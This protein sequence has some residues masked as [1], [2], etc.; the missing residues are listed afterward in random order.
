MLSLSMH[1]HQ[2]NRASLHLSASSVSV[3]FFFHSNLF[4]DPIIQIYSQIS[5]S[6]G[7]VSQ[8]RRGEDQS[9]EKEE[10]R[11]M[12]GVGENIMVSALTGVMSPVLGKLTKLIEKK[13][14]ELK[15]L[16]KK[17][18]QLREEL[19][20]INL[21][22]EKYAAV[23]SPGVQAKAWMAEMREL[24]YDMEDSI[25]LFS[26]HVGYEPADTTRVKSFF[27]KKIRKLKKLHYRY[28]FAE[29]IKELLANV[30]V[31]E[32]RRKRYKIAEG[33]SSISHTEIDPRLQALYVE[34]EKLVG[35][36]KPSQEIIVRLVD[37]NPE[38]RRRVISIVGRI[39]GQMGLA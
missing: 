31:A 29:E 33:S 20:A 28:R 19:M 38:E 14:T 25:D 15:K 9:L 8:R 2:L 16:R 27:H 36:E 23:E 26:H 7:N 34:V 17:L 3:S 22:L 1:H 37:G 21:A 18:E 10:D 39:V 32:E 12:G 24:A 30:K 35:I 6:A 5:R 4:L 11:K 13:H